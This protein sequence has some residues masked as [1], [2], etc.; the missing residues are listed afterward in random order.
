MTLLLRTSGDPA[1]LGPQVRALVARIDPLLAIS[2]M[3]TMLEVRARSLA[4]DRFLTVLMLAFAAVGML[5]GVVGVYGVMA[6]LARRRMREMGIR[7]ALGA[8]T[9]QVQWL[10]V[11]HG[12]VLTGLGIGAG[13]LLAAGATRVIASLLYQ[14]TP[15]DPLTFVSVPLLVL[16]TALLAA[17]IPALRASRADVTAVLRVE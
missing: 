9:R 11:R 7:I 10:V 3:Q 14:V 13:V 5:L 12:A 2:S 1:A 15:L 4:R 6:Q 8:R 16:V 17:W